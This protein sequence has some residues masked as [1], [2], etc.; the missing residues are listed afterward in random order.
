M[1][2]KGFARLAA[3]IALLIALIALLRL[4][5]FE[6]LVDQHRIRALLEQTGVLAP[7]AFV[8]VVMLTALLYLPSAL[9]VGLGAILFGMGLGPPLSLAGLVVGA[10]LAHIVGR[11][12][13]PDAAEGLLRKKPGLFRRFKSW[14]DSNAVS[15][16]VSLRLTSFFDTATNYLLG[17]TRVGLWKNVAGTAAGFLLPVYLVSLS[18]EVI[19]KSQTLE[20]MTVYNPYVWSLPLLR[21]LGLLLLTVL[22]GR[23]GG[24]EDWPAGDQEKASG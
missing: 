24:W 10:S 1:S 22:S 15:F 19:W 16:V 11:R 18:F 9:M 3:R 13:A 7:A 12:L 17:T 2:L 21:G 5:V 20:Q 4:Y 8:A 6:H 14:A 23:A